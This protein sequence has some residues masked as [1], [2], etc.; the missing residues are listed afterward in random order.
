MQENDDAPTSS[1]P[2]CPITLGSLHSYRLFE[3][4][5]VGYF[6]GVFPVRRIPLREVYYLRLATRGEVPMLYLIFNWV[7]F[8]PQNRS[9]RPVYVLRARKTRIFLKLS[10]GAHFQLRQA[11]GKYTSPE[12]RRPPRGRRRA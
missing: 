3:D 2:L 10:G 1:I 12:G 6:L 4:R 8:L 7:H 5:V 9:V 11:V